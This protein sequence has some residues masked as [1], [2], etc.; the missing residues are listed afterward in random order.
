ML[1][2]PVYASSVYC[3]IKFDNKW[4][5]ML[6]CVIQGASSGLFWLTEGAIVLAYPEKQKRGKYLAYWLASWIVG[7]RIGGAV[8][9]GVNAHRKEKGHISVEMYLGFIAIQAIGPFVAPL[10]SPPAKMQRSEYTPLCTALASL[11]A[12]TSVI[13]V[14]FSLGFFLDWRRPSINPPAIVAFILIYA[15]E[16]SLYLYAMVITKEYENRDT[17]PFDWTD[18]GFG[19]SACVYI[20]MLVGFNLMYDYLYWVVGTINKSGGEVVRPSAVIRGIESARQAI[21]YGINSINQ[22]QFPLSGAVAV[23]MSFFVVCIIPS[24]PVIR[25][26]GVLNDLKVH[27]IVQDEVAEDLLEDTLRSDSDVYRA[28]QKKVHGSDVIA[29]AEHDEISPMH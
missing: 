6:A 8:I 12:S 15:F 4:Y 9:F 20:L 29:T 1:G 7:Q 22:D 25:R 11:V 26:V 24:W 28:T 17:K 21:S 3:N 13:F 16:L 2:F 19:R 23:N 18:D 10:L 5:V 27:S 14:N